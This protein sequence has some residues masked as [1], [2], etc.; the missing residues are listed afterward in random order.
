MV[1]FGI[2]ELEHSA[3]GE[4]R[5]CLQSIGDDRQDRHETRHV[6]RGS[7]LTFDQTTRSE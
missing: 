6:V 5:W 4:S 7:S 3:R 2:D 1:V